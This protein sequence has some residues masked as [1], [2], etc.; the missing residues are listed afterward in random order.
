MGGKT[1]KASQLLHVVLIALICATSVVPRG[2]GASELGASVN[3]DPLRTTDIRLEAAGGFRGQIVASEGRALSGESIELWSHGRCIS[4]CITD[5]GGQFRFPSLRPGVYQILA[6]GTG[7][8][9]RLW[10]PGTAPPVAQDALLLVQGP[11]IRGQYPPRG[12]GGQ[13]GVY[14]GAVMK[15]LSNPWVFSGLIA[16]GIAVPIALSNNDNDRD[17]S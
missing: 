9:I 17:G 5:D 4:R 8:V 16:A 12:Y 14:D 6:N 1:M 3:R 10:N 11:V 13:K 2:V 15:T 7:R